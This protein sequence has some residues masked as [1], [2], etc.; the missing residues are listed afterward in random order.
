MPSIHRWKSP[1]S[2]FELTNPVN[3]LTQE[4]VSSRRDDMV[5]TFPNGFVHPVWILAPTVLGSVRTTRLVAFSSGRRVP[6]PRSKLGWSRADSGGA[7]LTPALLKKLNIQLV[8]TPQLAYRAQ[9]L[10]R[11]SEEE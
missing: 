2:L 9:E 1:C 8:H 10:P 3:Y 6:V 5:T 11:T 4:P 7:K